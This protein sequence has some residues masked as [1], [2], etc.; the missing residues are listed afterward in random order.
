MKSTYSIRQPVANTYLVRERDR[1]LR[2][3]LLAVLAL[4]LPLSL[5]VLAYLWISSQL[6]AVG[7][8]LRR[9][10]KTLAAQVER[11][12]ILRVEVAQ[13]SRHERVEERARHELNLRE[14]SLER[15]VFAEELE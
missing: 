11:E 2:R 12:R 7:Y 3:D 9:L 15:V 10:E 14:F 8:E 1:R 4:A 5:A 6:W 13:L